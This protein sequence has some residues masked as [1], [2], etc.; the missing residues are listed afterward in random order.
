[1]KIAFITDTHIGA[2]NDSPYMLDNFKKSIGWFFDYLEN[3]NITRVMHGGDLFDRRKYISFVTAQVAREYFLEELEKRKIETDIIAGNHDEYYKNTHHIN[4]L[5][6]IVGDRY[7][8]VRVHTTP[9]EKDGILLLPWITQSNE[10]ESIEAIRNSRSDIL[11]GH[12]ELHGFE[13]QKGLYADDGMDFKIF[14]RYDAVY[15]GHYHHRSSNHNIHYIGAF[16]EFNWSDFG[17]DRGFSIFDT[18]NRKISFVKNPHTLFKG[19]VYDD[20]KNTDMIK[21][22]SETD[23]SQFKDSFVKVAVL[24]KTNPYLFDTM[25]GKLSK[26]NPIDISIVEDSSAFIDN[27]GEDFIKNVSDTPTMLDNYISG[28][29]L[30]VNSDK[31]KK[32]MRDI[33]KEAVSLE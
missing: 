20:V 30:P 7:K 25:I 14:N 29:T 26:E 5:N 13:M 2:R 10:K 4:S 3:N 16:S 21:T 18:E 22:I 8:Y 27:S 32:F 15:T 24:N 28:L 33:Y 19:L 6:E 23:Y 11:L 31:M 17:D 12:L 9:I 1:M